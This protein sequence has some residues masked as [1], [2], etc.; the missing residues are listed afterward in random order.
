MAELGDILAGE[1]LAVVPDAA[2]TYRSIIYAVG[3]R[4]PC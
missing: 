3:Q 4:T 2:K 1:A